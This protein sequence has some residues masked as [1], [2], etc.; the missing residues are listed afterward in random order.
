M[1]FWKLFLCGVVSV[2]GYSLR[3]FPWAVELFQF[4][5]AGSGFPPCTPRDVGVTQ[6]PKVFICA[7]T[8][9]EMLSK[10]SFWLS[11]LCHVLILGV[12]CVTGG[13]GCGA[14]LAEEVL[15]GFL[16]RQQQ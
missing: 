5:T 10:F 4:S 1:I 15:R 13:F 9:R 16:F 6:Q 2:S 14:H 11:T 12:T 3:D 7:P 8:D